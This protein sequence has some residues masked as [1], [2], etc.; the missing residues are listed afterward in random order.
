MRGSELVRS[1]LSL[2]DVYARRA[3]A[4][5]LLLTTEL[6]TLALALDDLG[7]S[8]EAFDPP[9]REALFAIVDAMNQ[10]RCADRVQ[11]LRE[12]AAGRALASLERLLRIRPPEGAR[13]DT[14]D[15]TREAPVPDYG[16]GRTLTLGER[17]SLARKP[18][19]DMVEKLLLDPHPEVIRRVLVNPRMTEDL[20]LRL[21]TRRTCPGEVLA[22]IARFPRWS[23]RSRIRLALVL[24]PALP[25]DIAARLVS[26]LLRQEL[27]LVAER[28]PDGS[29]IRGLCNERL[30]RPPQNSYTLPPKHIYIEECARLHTV[31]V[32][33]RLLN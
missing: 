10:P 19:R 13:D 11:R 6:G 22:E 15:D 27:I 26:L 8:A 29:L 7:G 32:D 31:E 33:P 5:D 1:L 23:T 20:V 14:R 3:Y 21:A 16:A 24:N 28:S 17:K 18:D 25:E 9:S 12:E 2:G 30:R 4:I